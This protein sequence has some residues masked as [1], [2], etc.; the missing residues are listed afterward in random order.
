MPTPQG[1]TSLDERDLYGLLEAIQRE[2]TL[3]EQEGY[4]WLDVGNEL[5][6]A[7]ALLTQLQQ[8]KKYEGGFDPQRTKL[9]VEVKE[10]LLRA[11]GAVIA[12]KLPEWAR[13]LRYGWP[14]RIVPHPENETDN[15]RAL[16]TLSHT[17][18]LP[19]QWVA[20]WYCCNCRPT[21][22]TIQKIEEY[23]DAGIRVNAYMSSNAPITYALLS[24][25]QI[26]LGGEEAWQ[27]DYMKRYCSAY[28]SS[29]DYGPPFA[30]G[31]RS[32]ARFWGAR[33]QSNEWGWWQPAGHDFARWMI[34]QLEF[35]ARCGLNN[36]HIDS[37]WGGYG[38]HRR[39]LEKYPEYVTCPN[40]AGTIYIDQ[41]AFRFGMVAMS[42]TLG[43]PSEWDEFY[44]RMRKQCRAFYNIPWWGYLYVFDEGFLANLSFATT[45]ANK[46]S[47]VSY[48]N[49]S[50]QYAVF[51]RQFSDY[52]YGSYVD[53]YVAEDVLTALAA[54]DSLRTVVNRRVLQSGQEELIVH[55]LNINP[56]VPALP[57]IS[58]EVDI[59]ELPVKHSPTV[60]L[61][62]PESGS[63]VLESTVKDGVISF[64]VPEVNIWGLVI[65]GET[66]FPAVSLELI[67]R[68]GGEISQP[69]DDKF[70]P[71]EELIVAARVEE[72]GL[73]EYSL[74]LHV[75]EGW[76]YQLV[77]QDEAGVHTF[78]VL[79]LFAKK[80]AGYVITPV[81]SKDGQ[82][83]PSWPL[84]LQARDKID[85][86][87]VPPMAES[88]G[89]KRDYELE[90]KNNSS[91]G[92]VK[93]CLQPPAGWLVDNTEFELDLQAGEARKVS[94]SMIPPECGVKFWDQLDVDLPVQWSF[95]EIT[96]TQVL[97]IRVFPA[98]F[99][100]YAEGVA[101]DI[102]QGYPNLYYKDSLEE[103]KAALQNGEYVT[104][105]LVNQDPD[106]YGP[107]VDEFIEMG[108]GVVW[109]GEPFPGDNC[110][111]TLVE[112]DV[113]AKMLNYL[114]GEQV[115][116]TFD[117]DVRDGE[118]SQTILELK[119]IKGNY[120]SADGYLAHL[121]EVKDWGR[122]LATW[123]AHV[124][125]ARRTPE[126]LSPPQMEGAPAV[127]VSADPEKRI[128]YLGCDME[129]T[130]ED[131][132]HFEE[133]LHRQ[134]QWYQTY[135]FY[136][137]LNWTAVKH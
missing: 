89:V 30:P 107:V 136:C 82:A 25:F 71:G 116:V 58:L 54:P 112:K 43:K 40:N 6:R 84:R 122:V 55:I 21:A 111:V 18:A 14:S 38:E 103:A 74:D 123:G 98:V 61:A 26:G 73:A 4:A 121:V 69:L 33:A 3:A 132:Y 109:M 41:Q 114:L 67:S 120:Q 17:W 128:V 87:L 16:A 99:S 1:T 10:R 125:Y 5:K 2:A 34:S 96:G 81:I 63:Q 32:A 47:D 78:Q 102:M 131:S 129:A 27:D 15:I 59:S 57:D 130:T 44:A 86:R 24:Q 36:I 64:Q 83:M 135:I 20:M 124:L 97:Q 80:D 127:V 35:A 92:V 126:V 118:S 85:F 77:N 9:L 52:L 133:R 88:P 100:I 104:L 108:G 94:L 8:T 19:G 49:P 72:L 119:D 42:E 90:V 93:F 13:E 75:P 70:V 79:P 113:R 11:K 31:Q 106:E 117:E 95:Q 22:E 137:L 50:L 105:W 110:P 134:K 101:K 60:T 45:L 48:S 76:K 53:A 115:R 7:Q 28:W 29:H 66:V 12:L 51:S 68:G 37:C 46:G 39:L 91:A 56:E 65:I 62:T 23:H